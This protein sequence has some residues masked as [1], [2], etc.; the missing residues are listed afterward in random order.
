MPTR[1]GSRKQDA[2]YLIDASVFIFRAWF[3]L[4]S[5]LLGRDNQPVNAVYGYARFLAEL[6]ASQQP[7]RIAIAFDES[8]ETSFRND[9][10][11]AYKANR[12]PAPDELKAQFAAC[13]RLSQAMGAPVVSSDRYEADD[14]IASLLIRERQMGRFSVIVSRDKD[15]AQ[16]LDHNDLFWDYPMDLVYDIP[17]I[18][19]KFGVPPAQMLD[20]QAL[21]GDAVDNIP[22]VRGIGPKAASALLAEFQTLDNLLDNL[23]RVPQMTLRGATRLARLLE[24]QREQALMSRQL[25]ALALDAPLTDEVGD[26]SWRGINADAIVSCCEDVGLGSRLREQLLAV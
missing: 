16:L 11:P 26:L 4:P 7:A 8:L 12:E 13:K 14:L 19:E 3:S 17:G 25:C 24:E 5:T 1:L 9:I 2:V 22:G 10:Y 18:T 6:L 20:Y 21:V 15:L 23:H